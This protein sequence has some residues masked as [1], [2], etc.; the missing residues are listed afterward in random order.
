MAKYK[1]TR[2]FPII[3]LLIVTAVVIA[4][5]FSL[6]R[7]IFLPDTTKKEG[8]STSQV[9][10]TS[11]LLKT[12]AGRSVKMTARGPIVSNENFRT[13]EVIVSPN[14][15]NISVYSGYLDNKIDGTSYV[16]NVAA[17]TEFVYALDKSNLIKG[18]QGNTD[19]R[20]VCAPGYVYVFDIIKD[21]KSIDN[22]WTSTCGA[23]KGTLTAYLPQ[24]KALFD[25]QIPDLKSIIDKNNL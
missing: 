17:Y 19:I 6:A 20:G 5:L 22:R 4:A 16:N 25:A 23:S 7:L 10:T 24:V 3:L 15:R 18:T 11:A 21:G 8:A 1:T 9:D 12:D 14:S 13:Y 2:V